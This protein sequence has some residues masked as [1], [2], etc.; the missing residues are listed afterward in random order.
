M[1]ITNLKVLLLDKAN[2][3]LTTLDSALTNEVRVIFSSSVQR[4]DEMYGRMERIK[5]P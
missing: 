4:D 5:C 3:I 2:Y 1:D